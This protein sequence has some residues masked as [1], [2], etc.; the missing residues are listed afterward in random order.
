MYFLLANFSVLD[1]LS[2]SVSV[3]KMI[4]DL[5]STEGI[6]SFHGCITQMTFFIAITITECYFLSVMAFDRYVAICFPL[7]YKTIMSFKICFRLTCLA[8][9]LGCCHS[10]IHTILTINLDFC[11]PNHVNH[12]YCDILSLL[13]LACSPTNLNIALVCVSAF[14]N[15]I[16]NCTIIFSSYVGIVHAILKINS[17]DGRRKAFSTHITVSVIYTTLTPMLN[18]IIYTLRNN[19]VKKAFVKLWKRAIY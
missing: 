15:G 12:F 8:W 7:H 16:C 17:R 19:D 4:S 6:I 18:P 14:F 9:L 2:P 11:G 3:P 5:I 10:I 13:Q 1:L